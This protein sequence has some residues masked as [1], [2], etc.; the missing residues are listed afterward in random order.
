[1]ESDGDTLT[2]RQV[3]RQTYGQTDRQTNRQLSKQRNTQTCSRH[4]ET[5]RNKDNE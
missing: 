2:N 1:M 5:E 4:R 3:G